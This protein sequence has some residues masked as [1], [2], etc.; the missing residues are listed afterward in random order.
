MNLID[1]SAIEIAD[2]VSRRAASAREVATAMIAHVERVN[3]QINALINFDAQAVLDE[4]DAVDRALTAGTAPLALPGTMFSVKDNLWIEGR[5][6]SQGSRL[7]ADFIAPQSALAVNRA[8]AS[9]GVVLSTSNC[10]EFACKGITTNRLYGATRNPWNLQ[11]TTGGSSGGAAAAVAAG[12][13]HFALCT[14]GGGS[15]RRPAAH[16]GVV[17]FKPSAGVIAHPVGFKEPVFGNSVV[18]L[19]ARTVTDVAAAFD[20]VSGGDMRDPLCPPASQRVSLRESLRTPI[21]GLRMAF[22]ARLGLDVP[23]DEDVLGAVEASS[24]QLADA[25][26]HVEVVDPPWPA[27]TSEDALMPLQF[28][29]LAALYGAEFRRDATQFDPDIAVQIERGLSLS[30]ADM[31][32]ALMHREA[33]FQALAGFF[34]AYD[35]VLSPTTPCVAWAL[36]ELGPRMIAGLPVTPRA[37]AA[38]TPAFNHIYGPACSVPIGLDRDGLPIGAHIASWRYRDADVL[39]AAAHLEACAPSCFRHPLH[40]QSPP[41]GPTLA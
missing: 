32:R 15:T 2:I 18:G 1:S 7:F 10:S 11:R 28:G 31:A 40:P 30:A 6:V 4:A 25:G 3:P 35:L 8:R 5:R 9:G 22:S 14:D 13:G 12:L 24:R 33:M 16:T 41:A 34:G 39:R 26:V 36:S 23:V 20:A 29:G 17:G 19:M 38:F 21:K 37:H 27:G